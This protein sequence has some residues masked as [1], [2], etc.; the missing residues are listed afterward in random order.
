MAFVIAA[1]YGLALFAVGMYFARRERKEQADK[2]E[3]PARARKGAER[4]SGQERRSGH[5]R[6][7][8][9]VLSR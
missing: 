7:A 5:D 4:R 1:I 6:R 9:A 8:D 2:E 3:H